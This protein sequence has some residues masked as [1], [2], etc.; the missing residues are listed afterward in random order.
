MFPDY[1]SVSYDYDERSS[2][3][4]NVSMYYMTNPCTLTATVF[5]L[6]KK[7]CKGAILEG[8]TCICDICWT[9]EFQ[10]NLIKLKEPKNQT[11]IYYK[12][13]LVNQIGYVKVIIILWWKIK[14]QCRCNI[15]TL[16]FVLNSV[17]CPI[18]LMLISQIILFMFI[19]EKMKGT[20]HG[21]KG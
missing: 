3:F 8:S 6:I 7:D 14:C 9:F 1:L 13:T 10:K 5:R 17:S 12:C 18:E 2:I 20:Q 16:N 4:N 11:D 19:V 15:I 21:L